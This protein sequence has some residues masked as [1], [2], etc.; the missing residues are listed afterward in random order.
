[1]MSLV[2]RLMLAL[3]PAS[4]R[5]GSARR[6]GVNG[7]DADEAVGSLTVPENAS[8]AAVEVGLGILPEGAEAG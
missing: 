8:G 7:V 2:P 3:S 4:R 1:M 5:S 6:A